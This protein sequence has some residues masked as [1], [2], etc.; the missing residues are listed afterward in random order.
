MPAVVSEGQFPVS[1]DAAG[2]CQSCPLVQV[3]NAH[4]CYN[5]QPIDRNGMPDYVNQAI[6]G[7]GSVAFAGGGGELVYLVI[8][9]TAFGLDVTHPELDDTSHILR[10]GWFSLG[11]SS[12]QI[13]ATARDYW[14]TPV[15]INFVDF[16]WVPPS[17]T[18]GVLPTHRATRV[19]WHLSPGTAGTLYIFGN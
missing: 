4:R 1:A 11:A 12:P 14:E 10:A 13:G 9:L 19:R 8:H 17:S 3:Q 16:R 18:P 6:S 7:H 15:H 2:P 5:R